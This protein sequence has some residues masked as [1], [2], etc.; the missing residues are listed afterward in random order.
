MYKTLV[1]QSWSHLAK[2]PWK[3]KLNRSVLCAQGI[4]NEVSKSACSWTSK[5][6][7][8][9]LV[10]ILVSSVAMT[11]F[12]TRS[13]LQIGLPSFREYSLP[14]RKEHGGRQIHGRWM[15]LSSHASGQEARSM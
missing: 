15:L 6:G 5:A 3:I 13:N 8:G 12:F 14:W 9:L 10:G 11:R 4:L 7:M 1:V 2:N